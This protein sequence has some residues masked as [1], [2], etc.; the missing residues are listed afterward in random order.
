MEKNINDSK[1]LGTLVNCF[2]QYEEHN[3]H[4]YYNIYFFIEI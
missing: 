4:S 3:I 2:N 1:K